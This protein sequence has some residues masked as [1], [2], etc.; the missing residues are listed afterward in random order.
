MIIALRP[1][2]KPDLPG[3]AQITLADTSEAKA[4]G[5][6]PKISIREG[7]ERSISYIGEKVLKLK[8]KRAV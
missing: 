6:K 5:W 4:L 2:Y 7:L 8:L 1:H 3:E